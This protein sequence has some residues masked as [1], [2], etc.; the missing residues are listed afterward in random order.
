MTI[1]KKLKIYRTLFFI[2]RLSADD[3]AFRNFQKR[4]FRTLNDKARFS[5]FF[6]FADNSAVCNNFVIDFKF[7]YHRFYFLLLLFLRHYDE[8]IENSEDNQ[9]HRQQG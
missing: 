2:N 7:G 1:I 9:K 3:G 5:Y 4:F 8:K 6:D